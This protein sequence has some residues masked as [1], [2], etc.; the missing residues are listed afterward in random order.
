MSVSK[1]PEAIAVF[2]FPNKEKIHTIQGK[3]RLLSPNETVEN[4]FVCCSFD[5][6]ERYVIEQDNELG[7]FHYPVKTRQKTT[8]KKTFEKSVKNIQNAIGEKCFTK[9]VAAKIYAT[10]TPENFDLFSFF[11]KVLQQYKEAFVCLVYIENVACWIC[12]TPELLLKSGKK[13]VKTFS[14]AG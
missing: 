13:A 4:G 10:D 1:L 9:V 7:K 2:R 12:A 14:L 8:S 3:A 6:S 5:G 11:T